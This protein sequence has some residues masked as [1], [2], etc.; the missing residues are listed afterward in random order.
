VPGGSCEKPSPEKDVR[1]GKPGREKEHWEVSAASAYRAAPFT[2][3]AGFGFAP[4]YF[5]EQAMQTG[6]QGRWW[7][8][9]DW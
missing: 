3:Q 6:E 1:P 2:A 4:G 5:K 9:V 7:A 8:C